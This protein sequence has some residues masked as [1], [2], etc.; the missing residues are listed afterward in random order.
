[1][2]N[3][4]PEKNPYNKCNLKLSNPIY[5]IKSIKL[6]SVELP[7]LIPT[8]IFSSM[9]PLRFYI[10]AEDTSGREDFI[11]NPF[12]VGNY[13]IIQLLSSLGEYYRN[14]NFHSIFSLNSSNKV[15]V[16]IVFA[17]VFTFQFFFIQCPLLKMLGYSGNEKFIRQSGY[18]D[19]YGNY[20]PD[21]SVLTMNF[22][23]EYNLSL[24]KTN[25]NP[26]TYL[27]LHINNLQ[28]QISI[29][30]GS[31]CSFKIP[32]NNTITI[33]KNPKIY[34][35]QEEKNF[36]QKID[37][38]NYIELDNLEITLMDRFGNVFNG[39]PLDYSFTLEIEC[40]SD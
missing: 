14:G 13:D 12:P 6:K 8:T 24:F 31:P 22:D 40:V 18:T 1:V 32:L 21:W 17:S 15:C 11:S 37:F 4:N 34:F 38:D 29:A 20:Y 23:N 16:E 7:L 10:T 19:N 30:N 3:T 9:S 35:Y 2:N 39:S 26:Y 33:T 5:G 27:N 28:D 36:V 25:P